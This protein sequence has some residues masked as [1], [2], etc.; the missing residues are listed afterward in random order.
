VTTVPVLWI[1]VTAYRLE[2]VFKTIIDY[3]LKLK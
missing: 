2:E 3:N 1:P